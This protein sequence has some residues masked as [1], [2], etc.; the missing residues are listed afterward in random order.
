MFGNYAK[1]E[2]KYQNS[3]NC[4]SLQVLTSVPLKILIFWVVQVN[5][6]WQLTCQ[7]T[8]RN[9]ADDLNPHKYNCTCSF[10]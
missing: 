1:I 7:S 6:Y 4:K 8:W 5:S 10:M 2:Y 3:Q 9:K